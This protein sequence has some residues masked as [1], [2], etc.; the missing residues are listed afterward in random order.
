MNFL[1]LREKGHSKKLPIVSEV[2]ELKNLWGT[3]FYPSREE[4]GLFMFRWLGPLS[5]S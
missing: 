1:G 5:D 3:T 2:S 4:S